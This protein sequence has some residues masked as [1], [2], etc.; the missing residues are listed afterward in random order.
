MSL[1]QAEKYP[2]Q[3]TAG[4]AAAAAITV[5][6]LVRRFDGVTAVDGVDLEICRGVRFTGFWGRTGRVSRPRCGFCARC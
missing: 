2:G 6:R 3:R 5:E 1:L 4:A